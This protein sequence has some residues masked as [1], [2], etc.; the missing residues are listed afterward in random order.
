LDDGKQILDAMTEL[1]HDGAQ[2][3]IFSPDCGDARFSPERE[4]SVDVCF[5][6]N[7]HRISPYF[8]AR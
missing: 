5:G 6:S 4:Q 1:V 3:L 2:P 7:T 8:I